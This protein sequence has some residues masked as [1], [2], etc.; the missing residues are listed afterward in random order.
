MQKRVLVLLL[1]LI[2]LVATTATADEK[3]ANVVCKEAGKVPCTKGASYPGYIAGTT[4]RCS[5]FGSGSDGETNYGYCPDGCICAGETETKAGYCCQEPSGGHDVTY[6]TCYKC[7]LTKKC[8]EQ[9]ITRYGT[10]VT[11]QIKDGQTCAYAKGKDWFEKDKF[12]FYPFSKVLEYS[13]CGG[14]CGDGVLQKDKPMEEECE[15]G[16]PDVPC[17]DKT[18]E[19]KDCKCVPKQIP[20]PTPKPA[21][22]EPTPFVISDQKWQDIM[23]LYPVAYRYGE[24]PKKYPVLIYHQ[25]GELYD[26]ESLLHFLKQYK[27][28]VVALVEPIPVNLEGELI[29]SVQGKTGNEK[30]ISSDNVQKTSVGKYMNYFC[31]PES[32]VY[33]ENNYEMAMQASQLAALNGAP[34]I[35]QGTALDIP[36]NFENK[37][38]KII[39]VGSVSPPSG[40]CAEKYA[41]LT[42]I[43]TQIKK[44]ITKKNGAYPDKVILLNPR[45]NGDDTTGLQVGDDFTGYTKYP[46]RYYEDGT[47]VTYDTQMLY[48][49]YYKDSLAAPLLA[50]AK[51]EIMVYSPVDAFSYLRAESPIVPAYVASDGQNLYFTTLGGV[52]KTDPTGKVRVAIGWSQLKAPT[53]IAYYNGKLFVADTNKIFV[54]DANKGKFLYSFGD[55]KSPMDIQV[56]NDGRSDKLVVADSGNNK[57]QVWDLIG[58]IK[59]KKP[60]LKKT[61]S[62]LKIG[63]NDKL[64]FGLGVD[65]DNNL[66][67]GQDN[68]VVVLGGDFE[69]YAGYPFT[70]PSYELNFKNHDNFV[71]DITFDANGIGYMSTSLPYVPDALLNSKHG[72]LQI[73]KDKKFSEILHS[74]EMEIK[75][76]AA[77][78]NK[79]YASDSETDAIVEF[80]N[81]KLIYPELS[82]IDKSRLFDPNKYPSYADAEQ[83]LTNMADNVS[84]YFKNSLSDLEL[85][86]NWLT[87]VASPRAI[88]LSQNIPKLKS[89]F[90]LPFDNRLYA[91][92][93]KDEIE[94]MYTGRVMGLTITDT[95]S[96]I[97]RYV[98]WDRV[99]KPKNKALLIGHD[100]LAM[101]VPVLFL[102]KKLQAANYET[103]CFVKQNEG[104]AC[105]DSLNVKPQDY[106]GK[107]LIFYAD[108][109]GSDRWSMILVYPKTKEL[110]GLNPGLAIGEACLTNDYYAYRSDYDAL[111]GAQILRKGLMYYGAAGVSYGGN[112]LKS[113]G[114]DYVFQKYLIENN[115]EV[116]KAV[117]HTSSYMPYVSENANKL[118][119][120]N[121]RFYFLLGD[122]T[123]K[124][125]LKQADL[126]LTD[127][128]YSYT[129][130]KDCVGESG[131]LCTNIITEDA[132]KAPCIWNKELSLCNA[133]GIACYWSSEYKPEYACYPINPL[134]QIK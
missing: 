103:T 5:E 21:C 11:A 46:N 17:T 132:C 113:L 32:V 67:I 77:L 33:S 96:N 97:N 92:L 60:T 54:F 35:I 109:G 28:S 89:G 63:N 59:D 82:I 8:K 1:A 73:S 29:R 34:L 53:G 72:V 87:I 88:P 118:Y 52:I 101:R 98:F 107:D 100:S 71:S 9:K 38:I 6:K 37:E 115:A 91:D 64:A 27:T 13:C 51:D 93:N 104:F 95:S 2:L 49:L 61:I 43:Q 114:P 30:A 125:N 74:P 3:D 44:L 40:M 10:V 23:M 58:V 24:K 4:P 108:H 131:M 122:P 83:E 84:W 94:D 79:L 105:K 124:L 50:I 69:E 45:D 112:N 42:E 68:M 14:Y 81:G 48:N 65:K 57:I 116:G 134:R 39:C 86:P 76:I 85:K 20:F 106:Q 47:M 55:I 26:A 56:Y 75:S 15:T 99:Y 70:D 111:F 133:K 16:S 110:T 120:L 19:C 12:P 41:T 80:P 127:K 123:L 121:G 117:Q 62:A 66:W 78:G 130:A 90:R 36:E 128:C 129:N 25:E 102:N 22:K 126:T 7:D 31:N 18:K 119:P